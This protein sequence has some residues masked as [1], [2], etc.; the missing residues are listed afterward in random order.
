MYSYQACRL[1]CVC[2]CVC[3]EKWESEVEAVEL[4]EK[5]SNW[6]KK[7]IFCLCWRLDSMELPTR[8]QQD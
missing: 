6:K 1:V 8:Q 2:V 4:E 3:V 5:M 7:K